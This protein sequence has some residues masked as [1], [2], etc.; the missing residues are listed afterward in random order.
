MK[1]AIATDGKEI[2]AST[3]APKEAICPYCKSVVILRKRKL[4]NNGGYA[5]YW[6]HR[7]NQNRSCPGRSRRG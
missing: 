5:Y 4:M 3:Q 7:D 6:R 2:I 1:T